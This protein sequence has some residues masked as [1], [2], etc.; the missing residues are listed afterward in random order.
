MKGLKPLP[1]SKL[2]AVSLAAALGCLVILRLC[3]PPHTVPARPLHQAPAIITSPVLNQARMQHAVVQADAF[4]AAKDNSASGISTIPTLSVD[5]Q[6]LEDL[7]PTPTAI[8]ETSADGPDL[9]VVATSTTATEQSETSAAQET[10]AVRESLIHCPAEA[11]SKAIPSAKQFPGILVVVHFNFP[12]YESIPALRYAYSQYFDA[13]VFSGPAPHED[14]V[15]CERGANGGA[16]GYVC[17]ADILARLPEFGS[18]LEGLYILYADGA[19]TSR[20]LI[21]SLAAAYFFALCI[22][23]WSPMTSIPVAE[24]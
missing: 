9:T 13:I 20:R 21:E 3:A 24:R 18:S 22:S 10:T 2:F 19:K 4:L 11:A 8:V 17:L 5:A 23:T 15:H 16:F 7:A 14:V 1:V 12:H 6:T